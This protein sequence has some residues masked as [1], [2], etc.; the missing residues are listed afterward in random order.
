MGK[1]KGTHLKT[2]ARELIKEHEKL[3]SSDLEENKKKIDEYKLV[4]SGK[5]ER[6]QLAGAITV[7]IKK[8]EKQRK[9]QEE[10]A[11]EAQ[12]AKETTA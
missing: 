4:T 10:K 11:A 5:R 6:N 9:K 1:I 7:S 3:F 12:A 8:R 2:A